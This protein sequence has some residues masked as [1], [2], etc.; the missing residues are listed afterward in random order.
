[1]LKKNATGNLTP[2]LMKFVVPFLLAKK[3]SLSLCV[4]P[5]SPCYA[6][7]MLS[8]VPLFLCSLHCVGYFFLHF[9]KKLHSTR[10]GFVLRL[11]YCQTCFFSLALII[12]QILLHWHLR[13][14]LVPPQHRAWCTATTPATNPYHLWK[15][16]EEEILRDIEPVVTL[17]KDIL[18]SR[19][20]ISN[21]N[22]IDSIPSSLGDLEHLLKL[23]L[24]NNQISGLIPQELSQLQNMV[25]LSNYKILYRLLVISI[26]FLVNSVSISTEIFCSVNSSACILESW[27]GLWRFGNFRFMYKVEVG[28]ILK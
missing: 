19:R 22:I 5:Y 15:E 20:R 8:R 6:L 1:M 24:S 12:V 10:S 3:H 17:T 27:C 23:D 9:A 16:K 11:I 18:H 7:F 14:T 28:I 2:K 21:N 13:F 26:K 4:P 25:S